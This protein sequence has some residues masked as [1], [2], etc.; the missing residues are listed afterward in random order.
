MTD[1]NIQNLATDVTLHFLHILQQYA[2]GFITG[3]NSNRWKKHVFL[4][5][6]S[7]S[8]SLWILYMLLSSRL[9]INHLL[10]CLQ[11]YRHIDSL[12]RQQT[13]QNHNGN[14]LQISFIILLILILLTF[15]KNLKQWKTNLHN[16]SD[17]IVVQYL[18]IF[19][20]SAI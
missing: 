17:I 20:L 4:Q 13:N 12:V 3:V 11:N 10:Y 6:K 5:I 7:I 1:E 14:I 16:G 15:W 18:C 19:L 9:F 2:K 8:I